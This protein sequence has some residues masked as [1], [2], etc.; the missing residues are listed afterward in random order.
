M[1]FQK[2]MVMGISL[3]G[4]LT[5]PAYA[6]TRTWDGSGTPNS[7][8]NWST[9]A[10]WDGSDNIPDLA[11]ENAA[12]PTVTAGTRTVTLDA[13]VS[14]GQLLMTQST[15]AS[16]NKLILGAALTTT[17]VTVSVTAGGLEFDLNGQ[18]LIT[19]NA[20]NTR[21]VFDGNVTMGNGSIFDMS[22]GSGLMDNRGMV[23]TSR[24][25]L[26]QNASVMTYRWAATTA[27]NEVAGGI[28]RY[29]L[30]TGTWT[31]TNGASFLYAGL[32]GPGGSGILGLCT[33]SGTLCVVD[34]S[35][36]T[37]GKLFNL[38]V[39]ELGNNS[40]L[41]SL[42]GSTMLDNSGSFTVAGTNALIVASSTVVATLFNSGTLAI[43]AN[44]T[45]AELFVSGYSAAVSN[46]P[47]GVMTAV[48]GSRLIMRYSAQQGAC[49]FR[50]AGSFTQD[51]VSVQFDWANGL[52]A[53]TGT[54]EFYNSGT[55]VLQNAA[56]LDSVSVSNAPLTWCLM[57]STNTGT[58]RVLSGSQ[59]AGRGFFNTGTLELG[60]NSVLSGPKFITSSPKLNNLGGIV[61]V[62]GNALFGAT[63]EAGTVLLNNGLTSVSNGTVTVGDGANTP[64]FT[65]V[66]GIG[67]IFANYP[68][69]AV[70]VSGGA[71]LA[72]KT[73]DDSIGGLNTVRSSVI[74]N[75]GS[76]LLAG[77]I[78]QAGN[79]TGDNL[80]DNYGTFS[81]SGAAA[82]I[83]RLT[84]AS[85]GYLAPRF[86]NRAGAVLTGAGTLVYTNT[87]GVAAAD[88]Y[89]LNNSGTIMPGNPVGTLELKNT[90]V[91]NLGGKL[92]IQLYD[93][94]TFDKLKVSGIGAKFDLSGAGDTL[95]VS[96]VGRYRW[97]AATTFRIFEGG[98]VTF[99]GFE[100]LLWNGAPAAGE[101]S[102]V[103]GANYIDLVVPAG[104]G[105]LIIIR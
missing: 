89:M 10:N 101:Y 22:F 33:N 27:N 25:T 60:A 102:V 58:L 94:T 98:P 16:T 13:P 14:I 78:Q 11:T 31:L 6:Q 5:L 68:G 53:N 105:T 15:A 96:L 26:F 40:M 84:N 52:S 90:C 77:R 57:A 18:T 80:I 55:W 7:G 20:A 72:L 61:T 41:G 91:T 83:E 99:N 24:G 42:T 85:A 12:L 2:R 17:N 9:A 32:S 48:P 44:A 95:D 28:G 104:N 69:N 49:I 37:F 67:A 73:F 64:T 47:G 86:I 39:L 36:N 23:F 1:K 103:Y 92:A 19:S 30:N 65:L 82:S 34:G 8:G 38:G 66:A 70:T 29:Y 4:L 75:S 93:A 54:R 87:T 100:T 43:G 81:V 71:T 76:F 79:Y 3:M 62:S 59:L 56:V 45:P 97:D 35:T 74:T 88:T 50:N 46:G 63:N 21:V 51:N